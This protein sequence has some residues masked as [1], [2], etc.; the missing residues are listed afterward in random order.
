MIYQFKN[1]IPKIYNNVF[2]APNVDVIGRVTIEEDA[3]IWYGTV[4]RGDVNYIHIGKG[5][6]IQDNSTVHVGFEEPTTIGNNVTIGHSCIIHG[7][8]IG[9]STLIGMGAT[10]LN[11]SEVGNYSI[12]GAGSLVTK[13]MVIP[14]GVLAFGSPARVVRELTQDEKQSLLKSAAF[15]VDYSKEHEENIKEIPNQ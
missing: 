15:Y 8:K 4:I 10:L 6:N 3:N 1:Y 14:S 9:E 12:I 5:T 13:K 11:G 2:I 7:C